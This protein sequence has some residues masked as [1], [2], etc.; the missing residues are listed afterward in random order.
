[1]VCIFCATDGA[2]LQKPTTNTV[3]QR[4]R[5]IA[6]DHDLLWCD[7]QPTPETFGKLRSGMRKKRLLYGDRPIGIALRP[8]LLDQKQF[9]ALTLSAEHITS[10]LEK[11]AAA[12]VQDPK[13]MHE[14]G[15][16]EAE[17][18]MALVDP[19][20]PTAG[21]TTRLDAFVHRDEIKFVESNAENPSSLS[22]QEELNGVLLELPVMANFTRCYC[23]RQF[24]PLEKLLETLLSVYHEWGG[25]GVPN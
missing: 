14:L 5:V 2:F 16:T 23:L 11:I 6:L 9:R 24:S 17:R 25:S 15:L 8:H 10:A 12:V 21:V 22:D 19:G 3:T 13:L 7:Q 4:G 20:F 18:R 1:M